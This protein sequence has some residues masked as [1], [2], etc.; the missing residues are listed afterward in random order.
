[1]AAVEDTID[2]HGWTNSPPWQASEL[3]GINGTLSRIITQAVHRVMEPSPTS[4]LQARYTAADFRTLSMLS[5]FHFDL[6]SPTWDFAVPLLAMTPWQVELGKSIEQV[7][8][9][10]EGAD[11]ILEQDLHLALNGSVVAL[12]EA[13]PLEGPV[14]LQGRPYP[15]LEDSHFLGLALIRGIDESDL[16]LKLHLL[17]PL[18]PSQL[19]RARIIVKN[20]A[21]EAPLSAM[22]D[23]RTGSIGDEGIAGT[24][25][26]NVPFVE[27]NGIE[28]IGG[29][30]RRVRRNLMRKGI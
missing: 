11:G 23:W 27:F 8:M 18:P 17:T 4:P 10:G 9:I 13:E 30:R 6:G 26:E 22:L 1:M 24:R 12:L 20:G 7:I 21:M 2:A 3:P 16:R 28:V 15:A 14:Y 19:C 29:E 25:R 5:Y